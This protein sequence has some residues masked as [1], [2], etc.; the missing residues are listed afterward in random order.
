MLDVDGD[1][2]FLDDV[3]RISGGLLSGLFGRRK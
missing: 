2:Q 3:A 1:G